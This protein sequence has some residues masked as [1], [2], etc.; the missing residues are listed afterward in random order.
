MRT[1]PLV[2]VAA[3]L[4]IL[5]VSAFGYTKAMARIASGTPPAYADAQHQ[6]DSI[7]VS[8]ADRKMYL[9]RGGIILKAYDISMGSAWDQGHKRREGDMRT[10]EGSYV[11]DWR[12]PNSIAHLSLHISYPAATDRAAAE[13]AGYSPGGNI[14]IHGL[15]NGWG[16]FGRLHTLLNWTDGCIAVTNPEMQ[17]IWSLTPTGTPIQIHPRW[18]P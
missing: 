1:R 9:M 2:L 17:E 5:A 4:V 3:A 18:T 10:P 16:A 14:M 7:I 15:P 13:Q 8:K 6:T 12:N 11:I